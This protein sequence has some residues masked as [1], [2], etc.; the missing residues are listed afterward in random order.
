MFTQEQTYSYLKRLP[1]INSAPTRPLGQM[2]P[3]YVNVSNEDKVRLNAYLMRTKT[4]LKKIA[5]S[6]TDRSTKKKHMDYK[7]V[8]GDLVRITHP[9]HVFQRGYQ[10]K[11]T[12]EI[13]VIKDR[14]RREGMQVYRLRWGNDI[15]VVLCSRIRKSQHEHNGCLED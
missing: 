14:F 7:F 13:F 15:R 9:R 1:D 5:R 8:V 3:S 10:Q 12:G 11:W 6:G 4:T 2:A